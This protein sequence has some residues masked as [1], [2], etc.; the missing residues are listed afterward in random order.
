[1]RLL[2]GEKLLFVGDSITSCDRTYPV[3]EGRPDA[4]G[5]GFVA[6]F[7]AMLQTRHPETPIRVVNMGDKGHTTRDLLARWQR[8]VLDLHP[9]RVVLMVGAN[10]VWRRFDQAN[11]PETHV[12]EA[13]YATN[14]DELVRLTLPFVREFV[15]MTPFFLEPLRRDAMRAKMDIYGEIMK[16]CGRRHGLAV[17]DAQA[18]ME[19]LLANFHSMMIAWDRVHPSPVGHQ[20]LADALY[21]VLTVENAPPAHDAPHASQPATELEREEKL[22]FVGDSITD[23]GRARPVGE[24]KPGMLGSGY[25]NLFDAML[26]ARRPELRIRVVNMGGSGDSTRELKARWQT[27]VLALKADR[28][29]LMIGTNDAARAV[30]RPFLKEEQVG[31][32]EFAD[33]LDELVRTTLPTVKSIVLA[34]PFFLEPLR[35]DAMRAKMDRYGEIVRNTAERHGLKLIDTQAVMD[36]LLEH[37][38]TSA[39]A[40]DRVHP[41]KVG[42]Y[43]L[44]EAM[45]AAL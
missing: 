20:V 14:L 21:P 6:L 12:G 39:L 30:H 37:I 2:P 28:V 38:H 4:L 32:A 24:G 45:Y 40:A 36:R 3:G 34:T 41:Y 19:P 25:V 9:D 1:M 29:V 17:L 33:N 42:H 15:L 5:H 23:C 7:D 16:D 11:L 8:D 18:A 26:Q 43:A 10:D 27:D 31:E 13:E 22:L 35:E 44:A